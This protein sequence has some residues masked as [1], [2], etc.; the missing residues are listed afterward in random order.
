MSRIAQ[1]QE[2]KRMREQIAALEQKVAALEDAHAA[3]VLRQMVLE[4]A[5]GRLAPIENGIESR[6]GPGRPRKGHANNSGG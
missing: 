6:R 4:E 3:T 5:I 2:H 1:L